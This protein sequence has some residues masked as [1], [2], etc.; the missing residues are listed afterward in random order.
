[1]NHSAAD[2]VAGSTDR[3]HIVFLCNEYPPSSHGGIG[4]FTQTMA[5]ALTAR[6]HKV[7]VMGLYPQSRDSH[8][9]DRGTS[10][11][12]LAHARKPGL[13]LVVNRRRLT[14]ALKRLHAEHP[15]NIVEGPENSLALVHRN[16]PA[17]KVIRMHGGHHF[18]Y[19]TLGLKPRF[20]RSWIEKHSVQKADHFCGVSQF[21][22]EQTRTLLRLGGRPIE[23]LPNGVNVDHFQPR[24]EI[25]EEAGLIIFVGTLCEKKGVRQ[26]VQAMP[27]IAKAVPTAHLWLIGRDSLDPDSG[28]SFS[29]QLTSLIPEWLKDRIKFCG[30]VVHPSLPELLARA[31]VLVYPSHMESIGIAPIEGL[32]MGKA[33]VIG[34]KGPAPEVVEHGVSGLLCDPFSPS[35]IA[36]AVIQLM[37]DR[38]LRRQMGERARSRAVELFCLEKVADRNE[39]FYRRCLS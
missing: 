22:A 30:P 37:R 39:A 24:A 28:V 21:V 11:V 27:Q 17:V 5:R 1:M 16:F 15:I 4:S 19:T 36:A 7:T 32:A 25:A 33:L 34:N 2:E 23:I 12:R 29:Q 10:V 3:L 31:E 18:F 20:W 8:E 35:S 14:R 26:L 38:A 13:G 9:N 6:G